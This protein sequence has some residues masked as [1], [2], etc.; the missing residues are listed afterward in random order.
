MSSFVPREK[1]E[2][3]LPVSFK[4]SGDQSML[5]SCLQ[6]RAWIAYFQSSEGKLAP[7]RDTLNT[8]NDEDWIGLHFTDYGGPRIRVGVLKVINKSD[9]PEQNRRA[10]KIESP[11]SWIEEMLTGALYNTKRFHVIDPKVIQTIEARQ[12]RND[13]LEP[14][15]T[16]I[17]NIGRVFG[18]QYLIYGTVNEWNPERASRSMMPG[19]IFNAG[20]KEAEV[21][22]TFFL[23]DVV[24]GQI[25]FTTSERAR[26]GERSFGWRAPDGGGA[27]TQNTLVSY[28]VRACVNKAALKIATFLRDR[29]WRGLVLDVKR[30]R[31]SINA[32]SLEGIVPGLLLSVFTANGIV[33]NVEGRMLGED[34]KEI[35]TLSVDSVQ[36]GFS[37][38]HVVN[39]CK[40]IREGDRVELAT[41]PVPSQSLPECDGY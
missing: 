40:G 9:D 15:P 22:I 21:A 8:D 38:A 3:S 2:L 29:K 27:T 30:S 28:A 25:L 33:K 14:S 12:I 41:D 16:S 18:A 34:L 13:V 39:G 5:V 11:V 4:N 32:G 19:G 35:G 37:I 10:E 24:S 7:I 36:P 26:L 1:E 17:M 23:V 31:A 20:K 6:R